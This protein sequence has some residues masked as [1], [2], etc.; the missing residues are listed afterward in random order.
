MAGRGPGVL[1][2]LDFLLQRPLQSAE[3]NQSRRASLGS[4]WNFSS[5]PLVLAL[6]SPH[7]PITS[8]LSTWLRKPEWPR[9][10]DPAPKDKDIPTSP[11][12]EA[13]LDI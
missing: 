3:H 9:E 13:S 6:L 5:H 8:N 12:P 11:N 4:N 2:S 7:V 1:E 10:R